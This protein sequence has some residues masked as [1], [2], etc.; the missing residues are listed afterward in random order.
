[1]DSTVSVDV[2]CALVSDVDVVDVAGLLVV[3][4]VLAVVVVL[5][6]SIGPK[7]IGP[8]WFVGRPLLEANVASPEYVALS[9]G[10]VPG[11]TPCC[12]GR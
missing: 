2:V 11:G 3:V 10:C 1:V 7:S 9:L 4:L 12:P 6:V 5:V 8:Y